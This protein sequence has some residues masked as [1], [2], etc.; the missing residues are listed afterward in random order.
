MF[1]IK[2]CGV[3]SRADIQA[4]LDSG[5][6]CIGLNF[7]AHSPRFVDMDTARSLCQFTSAMTKV[8]VFV[9]MPAAEVVEA[10]TTVGLGAVQLHGDEMPEILEDLKTLRSTG[11]RVIRAIRLP[12]S[13]L[14]LDQIDSLVLPWHRAGATVLLDADAGEAFGGS[15]QRL[16]W[17][18]I[19]KWAATTSVTDWG[20]A[21]GLNPDN[22][23]QAIERSGTRWVDVA[24]GTES[25]RGVKDPAKIATFI[26]LA[27][28]ALGSS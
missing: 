27:S 12:T 20:L 17:D 1:Q 3:R 9:N 16:D 25:Q 13:K 24:S 2:I 14:S 5:G 6:D 15:G 21:G 28:A 23:V 4:V 8:G 7:F 18:G 11:I 19:G 10:A 26:Q 22:V